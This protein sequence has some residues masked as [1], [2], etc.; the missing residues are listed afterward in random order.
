MSVE[1]VSR[2]APTRR[3][4]YLDIGQEVFI[5]DEFGNST[6]CSQSVNPTMIHMT[7]ISTEDPNLVGKG[8][9]RSRF[10]AANTFIISHR[11]PKGSTDDWPTVCGA[12]T[13]V[14]DLKSNDGYE[15]ARRVGDRDCL[16]GVRFRPGD[17][18]FYL[19]GE[20]GEG[21]PKK[22]EAQVKGAEVVGAKRLYTI[23]VLMQRADKIL[24][25]DDLLEEPSD[26]AV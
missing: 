2:P 1:P 19:E 11:D 8:T 9:N 20:D 6:L 22:W 18:V 21:R 3:I 5:L 23:H 14:Y 24:V 12:G 13:V 10:D 26:N 4:E 7:Q 16:V 25:P 15:R 17:W